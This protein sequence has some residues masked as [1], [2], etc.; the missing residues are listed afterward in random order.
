MRAASM[1]V[2]HAPLALPCSARCLAARAT[3]SALISD[4]AVSNSPRTPAYIR[5]AALVR[6]RSEPFTSATLIRA[7]DKLSMASARSFRLRQR[8]DR[9]VSDDTVELAAPC[10]PD[11]LLVARPFLSLHSRDVVIGVIRDHLPAPHSSQLSAVLELPGHALF[12]PAWILGDAR[13][14]GRAKL[15]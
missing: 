15:A 11:H 3:R 10:R 13:V 4:S 9:L 14:S 6:S 2:A 1:E 8:R 12:Q 7:F 5:P